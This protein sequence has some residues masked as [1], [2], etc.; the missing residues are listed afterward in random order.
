MIRLEAGT[1]EGKISYLYREGKHPIIFLHGLGSTGNSF[2][3]MPKFLSDEYSLFLVDLLGHGRSDKPEIQYTVDRQAN[4]IRGLIDS[5]GIDHFTI[6]GNS[7]GGWVAM[8]LFE[9]WKPDG[10]LVLISSAGGQLTGNHRPP[11]PAFLD[12]VVASSSFNE[13][14]IIESIVQNNR[15]ERRL[16]AETFSGYSPRT[17]IIWGELD[18]VIQLE[19]GMEMNR[20]IPGSRF[21]VVKGGGHT[22]HYS[23]PEITAEAMTGFI[24]EGDH[25]L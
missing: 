25:S 4:A 19:V 13:R 10:N 18:P 17:L 3:R 8:R 6:A 23:H 1:G 9:R 24:M 7:Y 22:V 15:N 5:L 20:L 11:S 12:R 21:L 2:M 14:W 16:S